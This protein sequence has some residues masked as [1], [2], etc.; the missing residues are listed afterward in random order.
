MLIELAV[1]GAALNINGRPP[2]SLAG[3]NIFVEMRTKRPSLMFL[4]RRI[5]LKVNTQGH[6]REDLN[7]LHVHAITSKSVQHAKKKPH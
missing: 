4:F 2:S 1:N 5:Y 6:Y 3:L 7:E